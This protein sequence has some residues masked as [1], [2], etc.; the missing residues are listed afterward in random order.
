MKFIFNY[1]N[2]CP[3]RQMI[4]CNGF[5]FH[6]CLHDFETKNIGLFPKNIIDTT[7]RIH[8]RNCRLRRVVQNYPFFRYFLNFFRFG[9]GI[10]IAGQK[11][12]FVRIFF[13]ASLMT[14]T[15]ANLSGCLND[16]CVLQIT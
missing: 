4:G 15:D 3:Y 12:R 6:F 11:Y 13:N 14:A 1:S 8:D 2:F 16:Q 10:E 5:I 9:N 7:I